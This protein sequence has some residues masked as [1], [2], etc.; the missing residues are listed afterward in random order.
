MVDE[1]EAVLLDDFLL[2]PLDLFIEEFDDLAAFETHHMVMVL[3]LGQL[4]QGM[5][6]IEIMTNH[7]SS[8][9]ELRQDA[10]DGGQTHVFAGIQQGFVDIFG[11]EMVL[12]RGI[13][14]DLQ[15][16]NAGQG[17]LQTRLAQFMVLIG[18]V[19]SS[20]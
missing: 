8:R 4:E 16:L 1:L 14:Q 2:A 5:T 13:L 20:Q 15:D 18:H 12:T 10:I 7:Q 17:H 3:V 19:R 9:F 6:A 11:T